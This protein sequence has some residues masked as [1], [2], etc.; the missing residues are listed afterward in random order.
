M[1]L[2]FIKIKHNLTITIK[3]KSIVYIDI[4]LNI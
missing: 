1:I 4:V 2:I 3:F